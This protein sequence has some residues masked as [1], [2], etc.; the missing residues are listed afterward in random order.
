M[1]L[2]VRDP[3]STATA[4][5]LVHL[6]SFELDMQF[7]YSDDHSGRHIQHWMENLHHLCGPQRT[8]ESPTLAR[9]QERDT[10]A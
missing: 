4:E 7:Y 10:N 1:G 5:R 3:A 8:L 2:P 6:N 9:V